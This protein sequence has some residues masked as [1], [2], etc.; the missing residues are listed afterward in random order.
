MS[1]R[2]EKQ[3]RGTNRMLRIILE[4]TLDID[5]EMCASFID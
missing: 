2:I 5:E 3:T 4:I 1:F